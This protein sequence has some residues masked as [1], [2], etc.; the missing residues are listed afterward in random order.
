M[1]PSPQEYFGSYQRRTVRHLHQQLGCVTQ[2]LRCWRWRC[3]EHQ[4]RPK[5][6][7]QKID[8]GC[9]MAFSQTMRSLIRAY[10]RF[11]HEFNGNWYPWSASTGGSTPT[12]YINMWRRVTVRFESQTHQLNAHLVLLKHKPFFSVLDYGGQRW[13]RQEPRPLDMVGGQWWTWWCSKV[14]LEYST[15]LPPSNQ[16]LM[17]KLLGWK[18]TSLETIISI[19]LASEASTLEL[20]SPGRASRHQLRC[21]RAC[22]REW[23]PSPTTPSQ[24]AS[25]ST[26]AFPMVETRQRGSPPSSSTLKT[27]RSEWLPTSTSIR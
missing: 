23:E 25:P 22:F 13:Y 14:K 6:R 2:V 17:I 20:R 26:V 9:W 4:R 8:S 16:L 5:V 10:I 1:L 24:W 7:H 21:T 11:A 12:D 3:N 19:G 27:T 15:Y 18:L